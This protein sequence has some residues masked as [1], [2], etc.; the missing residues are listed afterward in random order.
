MKIEKLYTLSQ[1]VEYLYNEHPVR[2][3]ELLNA[4]K[5]ERF[6]MVVNYMQFLK[7]PLKKEMF[8]NEF[9]KPFKKDYEFYGGITW[10]NSPQ[11]KKDLRAWQEAEKKVIFKNL[12]NEDI[13]KLK[14]YNNVTLGNLA[15]HSRYF[16]NG[17]FQLQNVKL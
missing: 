8:V 17:E 11:Y 10:E 1:F 3:D 4:A 12:N 16:T 15:E 9:V 13:E 6:D 7:Q 5:A 14:S 2:K